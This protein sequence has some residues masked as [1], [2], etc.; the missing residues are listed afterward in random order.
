MNQHHQISQPIASPGYFKHYLFG[1]WVRD[2]RA[3]R[4]HLLCT[5]PPEQL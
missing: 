5:Q 4:A 3:K 2:L 1:L